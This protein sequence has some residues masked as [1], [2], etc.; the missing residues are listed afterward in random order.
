[1]GLMGGFGYVEG[2]LEQGLARLYGDDRTATPVIEIKGKVFQAFQGDASVSVP[3]LRGS[4][5]NT[6]VSVQYATVDLDAQAGADYIATSGTLIFVPGEVTK[7]VTVPLL[8][9]GQVD[10]SERFGIFLTNATDSVLGASTNATITVLGVNNMVQISTP[11][12]VTNELAG[13]L[14]ITLT[15]V[16]TNVASSV[17]C[18]TVDGTAVAGINYRNLAQVVSFAPGQAVKTVSVTLLGD[19]L[20]GPD[21]FFS[22]V[23]LTNGVNGQI[24]ARS[25]LTVTVL[26]NDG[27][28]QLVGCPRRALSGSPPR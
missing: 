2:V 11:D 27:P 17:S 3:V 9:D 6:T 12:I 20:P 4:T 21:T 18:Q 14:S 22:V 8:N 10:N 23:V 1:M 16:G 7:S 5:T 28:G 24:G 26:D 15:R 25:H 13:A 19:S